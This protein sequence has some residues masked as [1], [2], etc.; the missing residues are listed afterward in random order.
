MK[1]SLSLI[2]SY[3]MPDR[4][5]HSFSSY[6]AKVG[7]SFQGAVN[8]IRYD[9]PY[10][11]QFASYILLLSMVF[12]TVFHRLVPEVEKFIEDEKK[13]IWQKK[14]KNEPLTKA[15]KFFEHCFGSCK[16]TP[17][18]DIPKKKENVAKFFIET[19]VFSALLALVAPFPK[20]LVEKRSNAWN[21]IKEK[22][23]PK[24]SIEYI[25][26]PKDEDIDSPKD[27]D[28][29]SPPTDNQYTKPKIFS[30]G[31]G[32]AIGSSDDNDTNTFEEIVE[33][34]QHELIQLVLGNEEQPAQLF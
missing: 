4:N 3:Q 2:T 20:V 26:S 29:W 28:S 31:R 33:A 34:M 11:T 8:R 10:V 14:E 1:L 21:K 30:V 5:D 19:I 15:Q 6:F 22:F 7:N 24:K 18:P 16:P 9:A 25:D 12:A 13:K 23:N 17:N 27:E 32:G